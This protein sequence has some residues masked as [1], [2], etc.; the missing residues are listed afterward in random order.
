LFGGRKGTGIQKCL[1]ELKKARFQ[2][3][4]SNVFLFLFLLTFKK[5]NRKFSLFFL[6][7]LVPKK[8]IADD[9]WPA[10]KKQEEMG[11]KQWTRQFWGS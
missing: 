5:L 11:Q 1:S 2:L 4:F 10:E 6:C 3:P 8:R 9:E 7:R